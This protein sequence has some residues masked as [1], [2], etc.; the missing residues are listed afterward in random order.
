MATKTIKE[1]ATTHFK[2]QKD[3]Q[4]NKKRIMDI[5]SQV[6]HTVDFDDI[7]FGNGYFVFSFAEN[8]IAWFF[9]KEFPDWKFAI[10]LNEEDE[11]YSIFGEAI[12]LIDKFKPS[13]ST[14]SFENVKDFNLELPKILSNS[15]KWAEY[16][17]EVEHGLKQDILSEE[18]N[19]RAFEKVSE[20]ID[21]IKKEFDNEKVDTYIKL[22]DRNTNDFKVM[23]RYKLNEYTDVEGYFDNPK[24]FI[25]TKKL[26]TDLCNLLEYTSQNDGNYD[27]EFYLDID[28]FIFEN[29]QIQNPRDYEDKARLFKWEKDITFSEYVEKLE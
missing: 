17:L 15:G 6:S 10:W 20:Y 16:N 24:S 22:V 19:K 18:F 27:R 1:L 25:R 5:L 8:S 21:N 12:T 13:R 26:F 2:K 7:R 4:V 23:P 29:L 28:D 9:M 11:G 14:L 3:T